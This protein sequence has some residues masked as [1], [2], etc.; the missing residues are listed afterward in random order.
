MHGCLLIAAAPW[1][2]PKC[3]PPSSSQD[4]PHWEECW[5]AALSQSHWTFWIN[6]LAVVLRSESTKG[7]KAGRG[8]AR[9]WAPQLHAHGDNQGFQ[10]REAR[11]S[12]EIMLAQRGHS[13]L[14]SQTIAGGGAHGYAGPKAIAG[15]VT[16]TSPLWAS[17]SHLQSGSKGQRPG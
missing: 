7:P 17:V 8:A 1:P 16:A 12:S 9:M 5:H 6:G 11:V 15:P 3:P 10:S 14:W 4:N 2:R 13:R